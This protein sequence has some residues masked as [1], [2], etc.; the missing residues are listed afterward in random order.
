MSNQ[1]SIT[2]A[3][4]RAP[5]L[6]FTQSGKAA[7]GFSLAYT[8]SRKT[9]NG[10][11]DTGPTLWFDV[12][13]WGD[14]GEDLARRYEGVEKGRATVVGRLAS[15]SWTQQDGTEVTQ[16]TIMADAVTIHPSRERRTQPQRP[17]GDPWGQQGSQQS[18]EEAPF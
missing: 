6:N 2:G 11:E 8:P 17:Q 4:G 1:I 14:D 15:R 3:M 9:D 5:A 12:T 10:W 13:V 7:W 18:T 16:M